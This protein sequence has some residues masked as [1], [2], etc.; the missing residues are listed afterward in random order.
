MYVYFVLKVLE[1][2]TPKPDQ[3]RKDVAIRFHQ[4]NRSMDY[5]PREYIYIAL[6]YLRMSCCIDSYVLTIYTA[7]KHRVPL[8]GEHP[9]Y[10]NAVFINVSYKLHTGKI[11]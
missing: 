2:V 5:A 10:I 7:D 8:K 1:Q 11:E 6:V 4:K 3:V 9:D